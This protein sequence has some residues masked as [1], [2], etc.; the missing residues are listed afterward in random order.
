MQHS[1]L[2]VTLCVSHSR[3]QHSWTHGAKTKTG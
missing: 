1:E 2:L 3:H